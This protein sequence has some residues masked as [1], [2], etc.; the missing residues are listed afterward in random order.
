EPRS[1][2][3]APPAA[4]RWI[5]AKT[6]ASAPAWIVAFIH[7]I[8]EAGSLSRL[9]LVVKT[10]LAVGAAWVIAPHMPGVTDDYPY[11]APLGALISMYPTLVHSARSGLQTLFGAATGAALAT[12]VVVTVGPNWWTI[13]AVVGLGVLLSGTGWFG[14]GREYVPIAAL[15]VLIIGGQDA[16]AYSLGYL[17]QM[18]VGVMVGLAVNLLI[19]PATFNAY[20]VGRVDAFQ[21]QLAAHLNDIGQAVA[22][23]LPPTNEK[24]ARDA[25]SLAD[26]ARAVRL[27]LGDADE[28][29][30]GNP[31]AWW[32]RRNTQEVHERLDE[33]D[34]IAHHI[35]D[36]SGCLAD[37][38]WERSA[39]LALDPAPG[40]TPVYGVPSRSESDRASRN[41][42]G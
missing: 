22:E 35:R 7:S 26:T 19:P 28:S 24:W 33:L 3:P 1:R 16:D 8:R 5:E 2:Q 10:A 41:P 17:T 9:L 23:S 21:Q 4:R 34:M 29:N 20:A 12:L 42:R 18:G 31:R 37:T 27:A 14:V 6:S 15:F 38:T 25:E 36:I 30:R 40:R 39:G 32:G 11:Y 13:P